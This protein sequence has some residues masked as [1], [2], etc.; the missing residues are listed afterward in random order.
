MPK[1]KITEVDLTTAG[2]SE[3]LSNVVYV[4]GYA[5]RGPINKPTLCTTLSEFTELFG[6]VP[7][8]FKSTQYLD[9]DKQVKYCDAESDEKSYIYA[10]EL[11]SKGLP[12]V[13]E[14]CFNTTNLESF[15]AYHELEVKNT[16]DNKLKLTAKE[17]GL[18]GTLI[19]G[20]IKSL[21]NEYTLTIKAGDET[22]S[23][24]I[25]LLASSEYYYKKV[26]SKFITFSTSNDSD[27][28][29]GEIDD[30]TFYLS[31][32]ESTN[33]DEF[34]VNYLMSISESRLNSIK[35]NKNLYNIKM[36]TNGSYPTIYKD[37]KSSTVSKIAE[38]MLQTAKDCGDMIALIDYAEEY[39]TASILTDIT[40]DIS[41]AGKDAL[42]YGA[43]FT[44]WATYNTVSYG[45]LVSFPG[46]FAYL[47]SL[48]DSITTNP[49]WYAV[50]GVTRGAVPSI[51]VLFEEITGSIADKC[52]QTTGISVNPIIKIP[53]Y[54][55]CIW[56]NRTLFNNTSGL[57]ASSFLN[58]RTLVNDIK[59]VINQAATYITFE[60]NSDVTWVKFKSMI[61]PTLD[62]MTTGNG[63]RGYKII[64]KTSTKK[65][66]IEAVIRIYP[67][68]AVEDFEIT[69]ELLDAYSTD[70]NVS[71]VTTEN[72]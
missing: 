43:V 3:L 27:I 60:L 56:G 11:L 48:A 36:L 61:E 31:Y 41:A 70:E 18:Y 57:T 29:D 32:P 10:S 64:R 67:I 17:I 12:V 53:N 39:T 24:I 34:N 71:T 54:G 5:I 35:E 14:R 47:N 42:K 68:E 62:K 65:A 38:K 46:S 9:L 72:I 28:T 52:Q 45:D 20:E 21:G 59:K 23:L 51:S 13:F 66:T 26:T 2:T 44:P 58:I 69:I 30:T 22:E 6:N 8:T 4:P 63:I 50:A 33:A 1:I 15:I 25:S 49:N 40:T 7:Y 19:S 37:E 55:Y 16:N